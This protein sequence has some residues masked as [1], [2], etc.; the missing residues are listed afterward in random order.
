M[1][2]EVGAKVA[3]IVPDPVDE[4]RFAAPQERQ[5]EE[6]QARRFGYDAAL[7]AD[8]A[9]AVE[10]RYLQPGVVG[11]KPGRPDDRP[12]SGA[13]EIEPEWRRCF[14]ARRF[15][16]MRGIDDIAHPVFRGPFVNPVQQ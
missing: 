4:A 14:D 15:R 1:G 16:A 2:G 6:V 3:R 7:V 10:D 13:L 9:L 5:A 12:N 8:I 11:A